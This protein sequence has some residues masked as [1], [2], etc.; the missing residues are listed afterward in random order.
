MLTYAV[1]GAIKHPTLTHDPLVSELNVA[2]NCFGA[3]ACIRL[4]DKLA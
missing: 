4:P 3:M 2:P 1:L